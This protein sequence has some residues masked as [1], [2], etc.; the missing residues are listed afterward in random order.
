MGRQTDPRKAAAWER[1][2]DRFGESGLTVARFCD[3]EGVS[4][5]TYHYWQRKLRDPSLAETAWAMP[6]APSARFDPVEVVSRQAVTIRFAGGAV[7][8]IPEDREDL[9]KVAILALVSEAALCRASPRRRLRALVQA[10]GAGDLRDG[11]GEGWEP[12]R[13]DRQDTTGDDPR[14]RAAGNSAAE[15]AIPARPRLKKSARLPNWRLR[16]LGEVFMMRA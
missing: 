6:A 15:E 12:T 7:M 3:R 11:G 10:A 9:V 16:F 5:A 4:I 14:R 1:R 8:E 13:A 2:L